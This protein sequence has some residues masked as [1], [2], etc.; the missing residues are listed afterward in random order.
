[1]PTVSACS[2][3]LLAVLSFIFVLVA[4]TGQADDGALS[5]F[6]IA[7]WCQQTS[8]EQIRRCSVDGAFACFCR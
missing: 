3:R 4:V 8:A 2:Q 5:V 7:Y 6:A 1:M